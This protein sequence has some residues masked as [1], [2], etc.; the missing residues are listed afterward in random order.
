[1]LLSINLASPEFSE[2]GATVD[3]TQLSEIVK[4]TFLLSLDGRLSEAERGNLYAKGVTLRDQLRAL[5][6]K[7][8][9]EGAAELR[10]ANQKITQVNADLQAAKQDINRVAEFVGNLA[11]LVSQLNGLLQIVGIFI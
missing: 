9:D 3:T 7:V 8:F 6:G 10:S 11:E 4:N 1:M 2:A 5:L